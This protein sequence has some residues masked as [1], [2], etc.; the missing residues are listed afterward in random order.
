MDPIFLDDVQCRG[1][2]RWLTNCT[3]PGVGV[4]N[5]RH[6]EDAGVVCNGKLAFN[7]GIGFGCENKSTTYYMDLHVHLIFCHVHTDT[8]CRSGNVICPLGRLDAFSGGCIPESLVCDGYQDCV[9]GTD[10]MNC[11]GLSKTFIANRS[12]LKEG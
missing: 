5:C 10:E 11:T 9:G 3:H 7:D 12:D 2:E 4:H 1:T 6:H 8:I